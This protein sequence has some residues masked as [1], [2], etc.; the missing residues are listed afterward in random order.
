M[1][2]VYILQ[3]IADGRYYVGSTDNIEKRLNEHNHGKM[4]STKS[5][6]PWKITYKENFLTRK[7]AVKRE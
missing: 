4:R 6:I 7:K 1:F 2:F 5:F 3:S